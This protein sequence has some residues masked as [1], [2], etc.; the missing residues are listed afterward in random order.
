MKELIGKDTFELEVKEGLVLVDFFA[1]WCGPCKMVGPVLEELSEE[2]QGKV[3]FVKVD[4]DQNDELAEAYSITN[5]PSMLILKDGEKQEMI[6]G[7]KPKQ[8]IKE[9]LEQYL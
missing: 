8:M 3:K 4:V 7:F 1:Q 2:M 5:I 9:S 6:V